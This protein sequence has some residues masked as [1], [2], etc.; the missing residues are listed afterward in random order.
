MDQAGVDRLPGLWLLTFSES[1]LAN[2]TAEYPL[3]EDA[4]TVLW[5]SDQQVRFSRVH[6]YLNAK[7]FP[8]WT[9]GS[10]KVWRVF[11]MA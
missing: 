11:I 9:A 6:D 5:S 2:C 8:K 7:V 10:P 3:W 1:V 4:L